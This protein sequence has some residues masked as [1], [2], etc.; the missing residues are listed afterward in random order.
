MTTHTPTLTLHRGD[1][2]LEINT[3]DYSAPDFLSLVMRYPCEEDFERAEAIVRA[4]NS[5]TALLEALEE[6]EEAISSALAVLPVQNNP[7][8]DD[9]FQ[10][11]VNLTAGL[12]GGVNDK[13][14][15]AIALA[16]PGEK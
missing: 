8:S 14:R 5:H 3:P 13:A 6:C 1:D 2:Y 16:Q 4:C 7:H 9:S 11:L 10:K 15:A 12:L